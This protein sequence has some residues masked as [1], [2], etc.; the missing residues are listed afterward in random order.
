MGADKIFN[1]QVHVSKLSD[2]LHLSNVTDVVH[3][4]TLPLPSHSGCLLSKNPVCSLHQLL[5]LRNKV[6]RCQ[7][8]QRVDEPEAASPYQPSPQEYAN[9]EP[10]Y[11]NNYDRADNETDSDDDNE[12]VY[13]DDDYDDEY[14]GYDDYADDYKR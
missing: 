9:P 14:D 7:V 1:H 12:Y 2:L 8:C 3:V 13:D 10:I 5:K 4:T 6:S 11:D